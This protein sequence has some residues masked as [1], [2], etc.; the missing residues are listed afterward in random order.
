MTAIMFA[1]Y[2]A[3]ISIIGVAI[4]IWDK[5]AS[6]KQGKRRVRERTL[7][8]I[9]ALGAALPMYITMQIIR[10]KT[11]HRSF[12]WGFPVMIFVHF[13]LLTYYVLQLPSYYT[14]GG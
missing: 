10:H 6:K 5:Q 3:F 8:I 9:G 7:F 1:L 4:T 13:A 2:F 12:M 11:K 14:I